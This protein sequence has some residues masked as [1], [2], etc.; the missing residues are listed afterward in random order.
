LPNGVVNVTRPH[1]DRV[2][3]DPGKKP[4]IAGFFASGC[5]IAE[6]AGAEQKIEKF[7]LDQSCN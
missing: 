2:W 5:R 6:R 1:C 7:D 4:A 3:K